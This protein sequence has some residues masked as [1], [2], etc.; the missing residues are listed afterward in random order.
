MDSLTEKWLTSLVLYV[1]GDTPTIASIKRYIIAHWNHVG[2]PNVFLH[3]AGYFVIQFSCIADKNDILCGGPYMFFNR[4][5]ILKPWPPDFNFYEEVLKVIP[6]LIKLPNLPLNCWSCDS[7]SR[8]TSLLGVPVCADD[9][10]TR[11]QRVSFARVLVEMDVTVELPDHVWVEDIEGRVFKQAVQYDWKPTYCHKCQMPGHN[12]E[13]KTAKVPEVRKDTNKVRQVWVPKQKLAIT[14]YVVT[15][16]N[17][18]MHQSMTLPN[19]G[20]AAGWKVATKGTRQN[21]VPVTTNNT[22]NTLYEV[23][24]DGES[25]E[26]DKEDHVEDE[27]LNNLPPDPL[28]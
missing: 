11:Q 23:E 24:D 7:L 20:V 10:T 2:V 27:I 28:C 6:L 26:S 13:F 12:C 18:P 16:A 17:T 1:V 25:I 19:S 21:S 3:D 5:I 9:C 14:G 22:F 15:P 8:I 4:P